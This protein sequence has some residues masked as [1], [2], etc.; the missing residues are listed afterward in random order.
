VGHRRHQHL[1]ELRFLG[2]GSSPAIVRDPQGNGV[3]QRFVKT[4][5][6]QLLWS[7]HLE[8][9]EQLRLALLPLKDRYNH[10]WLVQR[11]GYQSPAAIRAGL[12]QAAA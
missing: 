5:K 1:E 2:V 6:E 12:L 9:V 11:H 10:G 8:T 7:K 3:A 4:L